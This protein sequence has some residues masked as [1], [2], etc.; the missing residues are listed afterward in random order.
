M[1][2]FVNSSI[3]DLRPDTFM[4]NGHENAALAF[5]LFFLF[6]FSHFDFSDRFHVLPFVSFRF[7]LLLLLLRFFFLPV[8]LMANRF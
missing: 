5:G 2:R 4:A 7:V 8:E 6:A 1:F 3:S